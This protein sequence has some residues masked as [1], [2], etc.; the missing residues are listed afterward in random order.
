MS[1]VLVPSGLDHTHAIVMCLDQLVE[2]VRS[3]ETPLPVHEK[4][5]LEQRV[6]NSVHSANATRI[7]VLLYTMGEGIASILDLTSQDVKHYRED[8]LHY[9]SKRRLLSR[10]GE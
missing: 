10:C 6:I 8:V 4:L 9:A 7:C 1:N 2:V 5:G 3:P